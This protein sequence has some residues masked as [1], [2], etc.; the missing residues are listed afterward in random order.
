MKPDSRVKSLFLRNPP[1]IPPLPKGDTE[2]TNVLMSW[3]TLISPLPKGD[4]GGFS[5]EKLEPIGA[6]FLLLFCSAVC[7]AG[8]P[9]G[10]M[11]MFSNPD[12]ITQAADTALLAKEKKTVGFSGEVTSVIQDTMYRIPSDNALNSYIVGNMLIDARMKQDV[13]AF[14]NIEAVY[15]SKTRITESEL[16]EI[17]LDFNIDRRVYFRAGKQVLQWGRCNLWNPTDMINIERKTFIR[18][19]GYRDGA[20]GMKMHIPFGTSYNIYA[21]LDTGNAGSAQDA[22][23][24]L[25]FEFLTGKTEMAFSGWTRRSY[26]PI[27]GFD[28]SSRLSDIDIAGETTMSRNDTGNFMKD[29]QG[30]LTLYKKRNEWVKKAALDLSKGFRLGNYNDRLV[31]TSSFF[32]NQAGYTNSIFNDQSAYRFASPVA[33]KDASGTPVCLTSGTKKDFL[34]GND[35]YAMNYFAKYYGA[36]FVNIGRF[37]IEDMILNVNYVRNLQ[38]TSGILSAGVTYRNMNDF[39]AGLLINSFIGPANREYTFTNAKL[40]IQSTFSVSF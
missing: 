17:F 16:R 38:D 30:T 2:S 33:G 37:I 6:L 36:L 24:A 28:L 7:M 31:V 25:K 22:A 15:R 11:E 19:I 26:S 20:Y 34:V 5:D 8:D 1:L 18:K 4:R 14:S 27:F 9:A 40:D 3:R 12:V 21:F 32:Y 10:E 23:G 39:S 35:L 29:D 13:K